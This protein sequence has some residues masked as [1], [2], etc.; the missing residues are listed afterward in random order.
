[1]I[2]PNSP[3]VDEGGFQGLM[4]I[5]NE[6]LDTDTSIYNEYDRLKENDLKELSVD[7]RVVPF[8]NKWVYDDDGL[9]VRQN[10]YRLNADAAFRYPN[11][12]PSHR[13]FSAN[14]KF[15][16]HE[17]YYLQQ[18]PPYMAFEDRVKSFSYFNDPIIIGATYAGTTSQLG[19]ATV[20]GST[21]ILDLDYFTEYFTREKVGA[22]AISTAI[23]YSTFA[24]ANDERFAE[25]LFRGAKVV[26][27]ERVDYSALNY[28]LSNIKFRKTTKY[29]DYK[30]AVVLRLVENGVTLRVIENEKFKTITL[31]VDAGLMDDVWTKLGSAPSGSTA[32]SDY[33]VDRTL[34]YTLRDKIEPTTPGATAYKPTDVN[35]SGAIEHWEVSGS[36]TIIYGTFNYANNT[37]PN[38][39]GEIQQNEDGSYNDIAVQNPLDPTK[40]FVIS[41]IKSL[42]TN[43]ITASLIAQYNIPY[44]SGDSP[45]PTASYLYTPAWLGWSATLPSVFNPSALWSKVPYYIEGGLNSYEGIIE[46]L[47]FASIAD[48]FNSGDPNIQ[49]LTYK[50]DGTVL[51][52]DKVLELTL[53]IETYKANYLVPIEDRDIPDSLNSETDLIGYDISASDRSVINVMSRYN[54]RYQPKFNDI[55]YFKDYLDCD[56]C[57]TTGPRGYGFN[58]YR[59]LQLNTSEPKFGLIENYFYNKV[60]VENPKGIL[61]LNSISGYPSL[62]PL[63]Q[64]IA[65]N[66][67]NLYTFLSN[68]DIGYYQKS[69]NK[70]DIELVMGYRGAI[71]NKA[72]FGSKMLTVPDEIRLENFTLIQLSE[73]VGGLSNIA[74]V[75][76]TVVQNN[77]QSSTVKSGN[78]LDVKTKIQKNDFIELDVFSTKA[79]VKYLRSDGIDSQFDKFINPAFSFG[80]DGLDDDIEQYILENVVPRYS[81]KRII[82]YENQFANNVNSLNPI[83]LDL[84]NLDLLKKGYRISENVKI[85][86]STDSPLNFKLIYNIPKLDNYSISFKVDLEKK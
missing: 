7:S 13:E 26:I 40:L 16:T 51:N 8:I 68:W 4:G 60:N 25:T 28:N 22:T 3:F 76:E 86:I 81:I 73:L 72:F 56:Y 70:K 29:N 20:S 63:I 44:T 69:I 38:F 49:Y 9:D 18:Y 61:N 67:R 71:E 10:P 59:N 39:I 52:N 45:V 79:L 21:S 50:S 58:K 42:S 11:F 83:E 14:P 24:Y 34:L 12:G 62:Y 46:D 36:D 48:K 78:S 47:S 6:L 33:F 31:L 66:K 32:Q 57:G 65:I 55:F 1:M 15:F 80:Q 17:W 54:G 84:S 74:N 82:F 19:I 53:P 64:E 75:P 27:K 37:Y 2:G 5:S 23:K 85:K 77:V 35:L 30:F 43:Q 41:G